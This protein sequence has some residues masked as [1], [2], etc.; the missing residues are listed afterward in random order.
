MKKLFPLLIAAITC[1]AFIHTNLHSGKS[2]EEAI[3]KA[4]LYKKQYAFSCSPNLALFNLDDSTAAIPLLNGWGNYRMQ[5]SEANDSAH[6]Y[7]EQGINMYY[8]FHIIESLASF[9]KAQCQGR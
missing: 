9:E 1:A 4:L 6:I 2:S 8:A 7:F 5:V 3:Q